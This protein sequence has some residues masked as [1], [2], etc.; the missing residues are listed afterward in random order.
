[1]QHKIARRILKPALVMLVIGLW[2]LAGGTP[3]DAQVDD[4]QVAAA[5]E[6]EQRLQPPVMEGFTINPDQRNDFCGALTRFYHYRNYELAWV[7]RYGLLPEAAL[8]LSVLKQAATQGLRYTDYY[9]SWVDD[10]LGGM[11]TRP[12]ILGASF[13]GKQVQL[14][15]ALTEMVLHYAY[16]RAMG[17][18][19]PHTIADRKAAASRPPRDLA[20]ELAVMLDRGR[21]AAF[22]D[23]CIY[24]VKEFLLLKW[25]FKE[26]RG[27][28]FHGLNA[29]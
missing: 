5:L 11:V 20:H 13:D 29:H 17:R 4:W 8:A 28:A 3:A 15:L 2:F 23:S 16:D 26:I 18:I 12:V 25:F 14:D 10:L 22:F 24:C 6:I 27:A 21:L 19:D 9:N 1:M 7:D